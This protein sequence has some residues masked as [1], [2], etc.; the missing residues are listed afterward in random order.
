MTYNVVAILAWIEVETDIR[1]LESSRDNAAK[2]GKGVAVEAAQRRIDHLK[3]LGGWRPQNVPH[4]IGDDYVVQYQS[5]RGKEWTVDVTKGGKFLC[6]APVSGPDDCPD[7]MQLAYFPDLAVARR[8]AS[9]DSFLIALRD[10]TGNKGPFRR[11]VR[12]EP[13]GRPEVRTRDGK[14]PSWEFATRVVETVAEA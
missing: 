7:G 6:E 5:V 11:L 9:R 8:Y 2:R 4:R 12:V 10:G 1:K 3:S 14:K 13:T